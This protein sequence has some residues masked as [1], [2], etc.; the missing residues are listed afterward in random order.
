MRKIILS[1]NTSLDG[2]VNDELSWMQPDTDATWNSLFEM[3]AGVDL[4]LLG[5][6]MWDG[7]KNYWTSALNETGFTKNEIKYAQYADK[8]SHIVLSSTLQD[9]GWHNASIAQGNLKQLIQAIQSKPG[10]D[11][12]I[13]G[14]AKFATSLINAGLVDEYRLMINPVILGKG[15]SLY[16][17]LLTKHSLECYKTELMD[18][19]V[20][21]IWY[22]RTT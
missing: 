18:N 11:I 12:Q 7:Y 19:G 17:N 9:A 21:I 20:V 1:I 4:L 6:G 10:K 5:G 15:I 8:T 16:S 22:R 14:G 13:V 3:L 2:M